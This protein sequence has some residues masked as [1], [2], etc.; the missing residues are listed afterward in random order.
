MIIINRVRRKKESERKKRP[1]RK[2]EE[3]ER[4]SYIYMEGMKRNEGGRG[5]NIKK[6]RRKKILHR[7]DGEREEKERERKREKDGEQKSR[8]VSPAESALLPADNDL[9]LGSLHPSSFHPPTFFFFP[10]GEKKKE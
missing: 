10:E 9:T 5:R 1:K 6:V 3:W 7:N 2:K 4:K 8:N